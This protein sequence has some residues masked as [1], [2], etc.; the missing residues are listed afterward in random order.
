MNLVFKPQAFEDLTYF[1]KTEVKT[2]KKIMDLIENI[3]R[4]PFEGLG[5]PEPL[6]Y[7]LS[8]KWSRRIIKEH[9][10]VYSVDDQT[11]TIY[12]CRYHY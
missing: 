10:L 5:K 6:K 11:L 4:T 3:Q 1:I 12:Q 9:R 8:G 7:G 2:A